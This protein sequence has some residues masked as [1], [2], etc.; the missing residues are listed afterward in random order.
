VKRKTN[1]EELDKMIDEATVDA[2]DAYEQFMGVLY[3]IES[4]L[5]FPF[6]AK[7]LGD[8]IEV[9]GVDDH[10]SSMGR[11]IVAKVRKQGREHTIS[12]AYQIE[13]PQQDAVSLSVSLNQEIVPALFLHVYKAS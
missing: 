12:L 2:Y 10:Q 3:Y 13:P 6:K 9:T 7:V 4:N 11:G 8:T 1:T 5:S